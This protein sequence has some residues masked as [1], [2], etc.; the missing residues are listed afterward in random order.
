MV[1]TGE[2]IYAVA[3][4]L[5]LCILV[6]GPGW[7]L[8]GPHELEL[9]L[10]YGIGVE[11]NMVELLLA[12]E[13]RINMMR[14][15]NY[16]AGFRPKKDDKLP[17]R[18]FESLPEGPTK[19]LKL[20]HE[21]IDNAKEMYYELVGSDKRTGCPDKTT[22]RRLSLQWLTEVYKD[23]E[24]G[25]GLLKINGNSVEMESPGSLSELLDRQGFQE[26]SVAVWYN[27]KQLLQSDYAQ[28]MVGKGDD[29]RV[30]QISIGG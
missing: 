12:G 24:P 15:F 22:M 13:R 9:M 27:G 19:G 8:Y 30:A 2:Q 3:D 25:A 28:T 21:M 20:D 14:Y 11:M 17:P 26:N 7:H 16:L 4:V 5:C 10:R 18:V 23:S 6:W 29:I 1:V